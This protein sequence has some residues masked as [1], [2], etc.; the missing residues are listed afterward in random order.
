[1]SVFTDEGWRSAD[2]DEF[3][4][5]DTTME[6]LAELRT[7]FRAGG[8]VTAG[9]LGRAHRRRDGLRSSPPR[10]PPRSSACAARMRLVGFAFAGVEPELMGIGPVPAT[11]ARARAGR[12]DA[13]RHR[14]LRA[15]RAVRR[16][17][18]D[19]VRRARRRP[20]GRAAQPLRR[21]DRVRA[22][23]G[24]DRR[25]PDGAARVRLPRAPD[26]ALRADRA[27]HRHGHGRGAC[28]WRT[29]L[30]G[31]HRVQA[32]ARR[33]EAGPLALVTIDNGD[34]HTKP[35]VLRPRAR[36]SRSQRAARRARGRRLGRR[37]CSPA[38][39][40]S[41]R[42]APTSTSSRSVDA[43]ELAREGS[44]AGHE[45]FGRMR[46]LPFPT[47]AAING[48]CLGGGVEIALHCDYRT[49]SSGVRHFAFPEVF[50]GHLPGLGRHA[51]RAAA[52]RR[53]DRGQVRR[54]EPAAPEPDARRA[55]RRVELGLRGRAA[56]AGR[57]PGRV[58]RVPAR[59][60]S[61]RGAERS[62]SRTAP[63]VAEVVRRARARSSTTRCTAPRPR[64]T[65]R[66]T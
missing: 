49:I 57:V 25:P 29:L 36:S 17:G 30:H 2:R 10:R 53:R 23:A 60:R 6:G 33:H 42:P 38:S 18:A 3:L 13:R 26:V 62:P 50:L 15:E 41:S 47:L 46:A 64:P 11:R 40:S 52:R 24:G 7:P 54:R 20:R 63:S 22:P 27:L 39:R 61:S 65:A 5:P 21:R 8:R 9:Q 4:R 32:H 66:S 59:A 14:P 37:W 28:L 31:R 34:D 51:A 55:Q 35:T 43:R 19:L 56:R 45:L 58:D 44:R 48:A 1:M 16:P 12:P